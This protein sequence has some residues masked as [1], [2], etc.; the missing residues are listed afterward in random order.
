[1]SV[2][3]NGVEVTATAGDDQRIHRRARVA[4]ATGGRD[5]RSGRRRHGRDRDREQAIEELL[6]REVSTPNRRKKN[7]GAITKHI[8]KNSRAAISCM[9]VTFFFR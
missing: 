9:R 3:V 8:R 5:R 1:M 4:E 2:S 7:A 6:A